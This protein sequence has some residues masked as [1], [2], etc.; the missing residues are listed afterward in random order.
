MTSDRTFPADELA[1]FKRAHEF[2]TFADAVEEWLSIDRD[3]AQFMLD[4]E[5]LARVV[6]S[7][8][9]EGASLARSQGSAPT[10]ARRKGGIAL[11][12]GPL[13]RMAR[14]LGLTSLR[15]LIS[16][17][18]PKGKSAFRMII[19]HRLD[20]EFASKNHHKDFAERALLI[21][22]GNL[23]LGTE[24]SESAS[25]S[26]ALS[27]AAER[28]RINRSERSLERWFSEF[29]AMAEALGY[30]PPPFEWAGSKPKFT[31][32]DLYRRGSAKRQK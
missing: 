25:R 9:F 20:S 2:E 22:F 1:A 19:R 8:E 7:P 11:P 3:A 16:A 26:E 4:F 6:S 13:R 32:A 31:L 23:V 29:V 5:T 27:R 15:F 17:G 30:V 14:R 24:Q 18:S 28:L 12:F 10:L 21:E